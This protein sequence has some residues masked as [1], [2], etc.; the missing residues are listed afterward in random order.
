MGLDMYLTAEKYIS[1]WS[2]KD[3]SE[4]LNKISIPGKTGRINFVRTEAIY[5][6]KA[7]AI[8]K[9]FVD[10]CQGG[11][12]ECQETYI[13]LEQLEALRFACTQVIQ[14]PEKYAEELLPPC[15]GFFFGSTEMDSYYMEDLIATREALDRILNDKESRKW[16][17]YYRASW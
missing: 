17:Y 1:E 4:K 13:E 5:W 3:L 7:N 6:R 15:A 2:D 16:N 10:H 9:W 8:H 14:N 12:D 11:V